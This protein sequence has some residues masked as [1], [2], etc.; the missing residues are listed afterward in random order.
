MNAIKFA[1]G[2]L[3]S[4]FLGLSLAG[5]KPEGTFILPFN[6]TQAWQ[7]CNTV[8][9]ISYG[10]PDAHQYHTQYYGAVKKYHMGED[11]NGACGISTDEKGP[12]NAIAG[13]QVVFLDK[14]GTVSGQGKRL[15][16]RHSF[17]YA[18]GTN[19]VMTF[20]SV[21]LH[22]HS[23]ASHITWSGS[24]TGVE[25]S[26]GEEIAY[27][28]KSG[29]TS[30]HL[31]WEVQTNLNIPLGTNPYR[32]TLTIKDSLKYRAPSLIVD[33]RRAEVIKTLPSNGWWFIFKMEG[34]APSSTAYIRH[35][36]ERKSLKEAVSAGWI[37]PLS[38]VFKQGTVWYHHNNIDKNFFEHGK[39]YAVRSLVTGATFN[40]PVPQNRF[41]SDRARLD[42]VHA[43]QSDTRFVSLKTETYLVNHNWTSD[44]NLHGMA[45]TLASGDTTMVY[46][47]TG[48]A[49]P[50]LRY[51]CFYDPATNSYT[52]WKLVDW[53]KL[54]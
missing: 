39:E 12:L 6:P 45:F 5:V 15:Y 40:I 29:T 17:P 21:F 28:G 23:V 22:L 48:K 9:W 42:M 26:I 18:Y 20:D 1:V 49:N 16:I 47:A 34:N 51:T 25:V 41:Q 3:M 38:L 14:V 10:D 50:L 54:Y 52:S 30:A 43:V 33:D 36:G 11:W 53:N 31:H 24:G 32:S 7:A 46:Q 44:W 27:L 8:G 13:G 19:G 2:L 37:P 35:K 4:F